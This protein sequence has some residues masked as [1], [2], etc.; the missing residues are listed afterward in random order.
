MTEDTKL[1]KVIN[2]ELTRHVRVD[3]PVRASPEEINEI[4]ASLTPEM[5]V[6]LVAW[7]DRAVIWARSHRQGVGF[8]F[9]PDEA[10]W[11]TD[12][13]IV[14]NAKLEPTR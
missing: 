8:R 11:E 3:H 9:D 7:Y 1:R 10:L 13:E 12:P 2:H 4:L 5:R 6:D 14:A